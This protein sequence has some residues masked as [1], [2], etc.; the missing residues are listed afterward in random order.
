MNIQKLF[1]WTVLLALIAGTQSC[2]DEESLNLNLTEVSTLYTPEDNRSITITGDNSETIE[3]F[4]WDQAR[5]EDGSLVLYEVAFDQENGDFS[6]PFYR[7]VSNNKGVETRL[8][9]SYSALNEIAA[10]GGAAI[11]EKKK[12]KWTV[13]ASKGSNVK[14]ALV[15]RIIEIERPKGIP[16]PPATAYIT[17]TA[18]E[19]GTDLLSAKVFRQTS[20][21]KFEIYTKLTAGSYK[22]VDT[23]EEGG[24]VFS[25]T[26]SNG[27]MVVNEEA[28][29]STYEGEDKVYRI[30]IDFKAGSAKFEEVKAVGFWYANQDKILY[31]L[32]YTG[33]GVFKAENVTVNLDAE[34]WGLEERHK[35]RVTLNNGSS[36]FE[37]WWGY[38]GDDSPSQDGTYGTA[39]DEYFYAFLVPN[40]DRWNHSWK[41]DRNA[42][43]GKQVTFI[44]S[45]NGETDYHMDYI[46]L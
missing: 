7:V 45:F 35:Y 38:K 2:R 40:P 32:A 30:T 16:N 19:G 12:F 3:T 8:D 15:S 22:V 5:A 43:Q 26:E 39:P 20:P 9:L 13:M 18:T 34:S 25:I 11:L 4:E 36:D 17:G 24:R 28:V 21:G 10:L 27:A 41:L 46:I 37:E 6:S 14:K 29:E 42:V 31:D 1:S 33:E 44:L 23:Q